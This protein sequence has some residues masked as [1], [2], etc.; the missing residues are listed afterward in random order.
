M[1]KIIWDNRYVC[2][3]LAIVGIFVFLFLL[4]G[5]IDSDDDG[6]VFLKWQKLLIYMSLD[7]FLTVVFFLRFTDISGKS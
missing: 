1:R 5:A 3:G 4:T 7:L 2:L 6:Y